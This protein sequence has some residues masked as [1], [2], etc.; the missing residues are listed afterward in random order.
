MKYTYTNPTIPEFALP[1]QSGARYTTLAP[2]T[3]D[4]QERA[5][6][7]IQGLTGRTDPESDYEIYYV[8]ALGLNPPFLGHWRWDIWNQMWYHAALPLMRLISGSDHNAHVEEHWTRVLLHMQAPDG[9]LYEKIEDR[10]WLAFNAPG[11][12]GSSTGDRSSLISSAWGM[13]VLTL[14]AHLTGDPLWRK[15]GQRIVDGLAAQVVDKGEYAYF[16]RS[17]LPWTDPSMPNPH[18]ISHGGWAVHAL[19]FFYRET[20]YEPALA[21]AG[22]LVRA[23]KDH[24]S[25]FDPQGKFLPC[26]RRPGPEAHFYAHVHCLLETLDYAVAAGGDQDLIDFARRGFEYARANGER[27]TGYFPEY[28]AHS[29]RDFQMCE[30]CGLADMIGLGLRLS[31]LGLGDYWDDVD[32]WIRNQFAEQQL[33]RADWMERLPWMGPERGWFNTTSGWYQ[34]D[35]RRQKFAGLADACLGSFSS[36]A[37][38]NDWLAGDERNYLAMI[39]CCTGT[40]SRALYFAWEHILRH[41]AGKLRINLLLNRASPWADVNS[42]I[43]YEGQVDIHIKQEVA[44]TVRIPEWVQPHE[45]TCTV[46]HEGRQVGWEGRYA[47]VGQAPAGAQVTLRFPI[48][49]RQHWIHIDKKPYSLVCKGNEVVAIEPAGQYHPLY[50]RDHYRD[51]VVHWKTVSRFVSATELYW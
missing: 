20:G 2:A 1:A 23:I 9:L 44:L 43:P 22:K 21:L 14:Y 32:R 42:Y 26:Q 4:L 7:A 3:L 51:T 41:E 29:R 36:S 31:A 38:P 24:G 47:Q 37:A 46:N 16:P 49:E 35:P 18:M 17:V 12:H 27:L 50:Q 30:T 34:P 10:P 40:G 15:A 39:G 48:Q 45:V 28:I 33:T 5:A 13:T 8:T 19:T 11:T 25:Y 6:L